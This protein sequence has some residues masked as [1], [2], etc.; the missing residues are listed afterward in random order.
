[1]DLLGKVLS[2]SR[3]L[4]HTMPF[5]HHYRDLVHLLPA[6]S[7]IDNSKLLSPQNCDQTFPKQ[8]PG[9]SIVKWF[10]FLWLEY[11][12]YK[13]PILITTF[14]RPGTG[15]DIECWKNLF[16]V[17]SSIATYL[18][19][20]SFWTNNFMRNKKKSIC[21]IFCPCKHFCSYYLSLIRCLHPER[22]AFYESQ[23]SHWEG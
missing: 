5:D 6:A 1:M 22:S 12:F 13:T 21:F 17:G 14:R 10:Y 8:A 11:A 4:A 23:K 7:E 9:S 3:Q 16:T 19:A 15:R 2:F 20:V 18:F